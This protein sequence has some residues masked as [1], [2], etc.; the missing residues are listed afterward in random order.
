[1]RLGLPGGGEG[2]G[3]P[4][5]LGLPGSAPPSSKLHGAGAASQGK[6]VPGEAG[7]PACSGVVCHL[8]VLPGEELRLPRAA[9]LAAGVSRAVIRCYRD[10]FWLCHE[11]LCVCFNGS[12]S[13]GACGGLNPSGTPLMEVMGEMVSLC[14]K[15]RGKK[16]RRESKQME[17]KM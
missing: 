14:L 13:S 2:S 17:S 4:A 9:R 8:L 12:S 1:M 5:K 16:I 11:V 15:L 7:F 3:D 10:V 6:L